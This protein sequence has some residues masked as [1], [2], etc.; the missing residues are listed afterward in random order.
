M[1]TRVVV[2]DAR[3]LADAVV[4]L[5]QRELFAFADRRQRPPEGRRLLAAEINRFTSGQPHAEHREGGVCGPLHFLGVIEVG[6]VADR[7]DQFRIVHPARIPPPI[8]A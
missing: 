5:V 4:E 3:Q 7:V 2:P 8:S 6:V 1:P